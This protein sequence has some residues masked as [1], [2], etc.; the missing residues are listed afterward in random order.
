M[1]QPDINKTAMILDMLDWHK[2]LNDRNITLLYSGPLW[3]Q[4]I[5]E[6]AG[7]LKNRLEFDGMTLYASQEIYSVF[8]EQ[9]NNML[10]YSAE[11][12]RFKIAD[13]KNNESP[14]GTFIVG[15]TGEGEKNYFIQ[16]G[17]FMESKNVEYL[18]NKIDHINTLDKNDLHK[19][20]KEQMKLKDSNLQSKGCGLGFIEIARRTSSKM[21]Y[22]FIPYK[23]DIVFFI[24]YVTIGGGYERV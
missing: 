1:Q 22:S 23:G 24:L 18:K 11:K 8:I 2:M 10:M 20:F 17:N 4:G 16:T 12:T 9:M 3:S 6:I 21:E 7:T 19:Y 14:K 13:G 15:S 5:S